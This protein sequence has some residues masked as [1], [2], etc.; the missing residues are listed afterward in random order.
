MKNIEKKKV[1]KRNSSKLT[2]Y[3]PNEY[4]FRRKK[5]VRSLIFEMKLAYYI[6]WLVLAK[7]NQYDQSVKTIA[8]NTNAKHMLKNWGKKLNDETAIYFSLKDILV[9]RYLP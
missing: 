9:S 3:I 8:H 6:L 5:L 4:T 1:T 2:T 7:L